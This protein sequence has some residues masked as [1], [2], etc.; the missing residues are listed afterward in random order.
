MWK[1]VLVVNI[2]LVVVFG[3]LIIIANSFNS[4][5]F[6]NTAEEFLGWAIVI[7][8]PI[9][10]LLSSVVIYRRLDSMKTKSLAFKSTVLLPT[11]IS[12]IYSLWVFWIIGFS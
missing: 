7:V 10:L 4:I 3:G 12:G 1:V 5:A 9:L 2:L 11:L 8:L 6:A